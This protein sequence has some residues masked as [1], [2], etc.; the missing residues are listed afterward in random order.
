M[1]VIKAEE[2]SLEVTTLWRKNCTGKQ[3]RYLVNNTG[4]GE[5]VSRPW[6]LGTLRKNQVRKIGKIRF[7]QS[8]I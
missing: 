4:A 1:G 7:N 3:R 8:L 6:A 5:E 2:T